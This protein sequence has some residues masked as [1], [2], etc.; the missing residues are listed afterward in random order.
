MKF[1]SRVIAPLSIIFLIPSDKYNCLS[2][3][4]VVD[5][6]ASCTS[7]L[8][9]KFW[10]TPLSRSTAVF[11]THEGVEGL[12][13]VD[14][15]KA[16]LLT[17]VSSKV[18]S[19]EKFDYE[20]HWY[21]CI[22]ERDLVVDEPTK[23]TI[24]DVD[25][26]I[27]KTSKSGEVIAL[28]D[29]CTH[30]GAA[31]SE[32][33]V[34]V[35]GNFQCAYHGWSFNGKTGECVEIPQILK[36]SDDKSQKGETSAKIPSRACSIAVPAQVHQGMVWLFP[37]GGLES[38][39][40]APSPPSL[41]KTFKNMKMSTTMRDFPIDFPILLSNICDPDHGLFAHQSK[42]FDMYTASLD[43]NFE[44]FVSEETDEGRGWSLKTTVDS[45]DKLIELDQSL[46][47]RMNQKQTKKKKSSKNTISPW[48]TF[49]FQA[50]THVRMNRVQKE[51]GE[52][53][54]ASIFYVCPVGVGRS[55]FMAATVSGIELPRWLLYMN[56]LNFLDQDT[57]LL[58]TQQQSL[59]RKE[60]SD[61][62]ELMKE[63]GIQRGD[64]E[65]VKKLRLRTRRNCF[66]LP[67]PTDR[68]SSKIEQFWDATLARCPNR[69]EN[70][71][72]LDES[73]A[74]LETPS[75]EVVLDRETQVLGISK[76]SRDVVRNCRIVRRV[77][78]MLSV[79]LG[80]SKII[81]MNSPLSEVMK[82]LLKSYYFI[83]K[84][85]F[86]Y[87]ISFL[88]KKIEKQYYFKYTGD[89]RRRDLKKIP[90]EIWVD[91]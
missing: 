81:S 72:K 51:T 32:G 85:L 57:Y 27:A 33:R 13:E 88:A 29:Y 78:K 22:W 48:A 12:S 69:V 31:L 89:Y 75:R 24:F 73:G 47:E 61:L 26:V 36:I 56:F 6:F 91:R 87:G 28:K 2:K 41:P 65:G 50:P 16:S 74:F 1:V 66:C 23:V 17:S 18:S 7:D 8:C 34:T 25:Y 60:A 20:D 3:V 38:A 49:Q 77:T 86:L 83:S 59:L 84:L 14:G 11:S 80:I 70:L 63:H 68:I 19:F 52:T 4:N 79:M 64:K 5:A 46:R 10:K 82:Q 67:S 39:L 58:A 15:G 55:R 44:S 30:K 90:K 53:K 54:F 37:G 35:G 9:K 42:N 43:C 21:P 45:K 76:V 40:T 62:R 71:L